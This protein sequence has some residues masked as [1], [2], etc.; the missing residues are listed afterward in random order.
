MPFRS[1]PVLTRLQ[2]NQEVSIEMFPVFRIRL[3]KLDVVN[4][5]FGKIIGALVWTSIFGVFI[6]FCS[7]FVTSPD[8]LLF[9]KNAI[10]FGLFIALRRKDGRT[11]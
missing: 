1:N 5:K 4:D 2:G 10:N 3:T 8:F 11:V 7:M 6:F 9:L